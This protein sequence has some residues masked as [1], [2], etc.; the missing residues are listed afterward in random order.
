MNEIKVLLKKVGIFSSFPEEE[1]SEIA[2]KSKIL[3]MKG[4]DYVF[5][6]GDVGGGFYIIV[7]GEV[8]VVKKIADDDIHITTLRKGEMFGES[9]IIAPF[10]EKR[11]ASVFVRNKAKLINIPKECIEN[12]TTKNPK[13]FLLFFRYIG[14][15]ILQRL[16]KMD[17]EYLKVLIE[18]KGKDKFLD[19]KIKI[20][21]E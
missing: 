21:K 4:G 16:R 3:D 7:E 19:T 9:D 12:L 5:K 11:M 20:F 2:Q 10:G 13:L 6:E 18:F 15:T 14:H 17:E 1:L 8:E